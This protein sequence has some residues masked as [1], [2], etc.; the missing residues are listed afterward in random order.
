MR[1]FADCRGYASPLIGVHRYM[2]FEWPKPVRGWRGVR[3][4]LAVVVLGVLIA[5]WAGQGAQSF[6]DRNRA[7]VAHSPPPTNRLRPLKTHV[8]MLPN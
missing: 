3:D 1:P 4:E 5:L 6:T 7:S 2:R 8:A